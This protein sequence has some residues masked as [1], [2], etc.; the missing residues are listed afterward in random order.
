MVVLD[1]VWIPLVRLAA[2]EAVVALEAAAERPLTLRG[3]HVHLVLRTE[4]PF[5]D[6]V[7]VPALLAEHLGDVRALEGDVTVRVREAGGGFGDTGHAVRR[8]VSPGQQAGA[9]RRAQR[10]GVEVRVSDAAVG[11][12]LDVRRLD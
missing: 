12:P 11:D 5:S 3:R 4:V 1:Q 10:R 8:V 2:E 9:G 7:G 6:V